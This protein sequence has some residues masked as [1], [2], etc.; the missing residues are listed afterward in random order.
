MRGDMKANINRLLLFQNIITHV[1]KT[2]NI[3]YIYS[4][5]FY[6]SVNMTDKKSIKIK[7]EGKYLFYKN[8]VY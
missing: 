6:C 7:A 3:L 2:T 8:S 1:N 5:L 4:F